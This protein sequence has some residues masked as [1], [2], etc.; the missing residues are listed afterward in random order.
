MGS[1]SDGW[2]P[3]SEWA[4]G[5]ALTEIHPR[6][7]TAVVAAVALCEM[8]KAG[9][10]VEQSGPSWRGWRPSQPDGIH[11]LTQGNLVLPRLVPIGVE[12]SN[13]CMDLV[14]QG[15]GRTR[16]DLRV[17]VHWVARTRC[18]FRDIIV[19][20]G[21]GLVKAPELHPRQ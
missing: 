8:I 19:G 15:L 18:G 12:A 6:K 3:P 1:H 4:R 10:A 7:I 14:G 11:V 5:W 9:L 21:I 13:E 16:G 2:Y 20:L 17:A